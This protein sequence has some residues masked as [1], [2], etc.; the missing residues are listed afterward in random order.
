MYSIKPYL[1][2]L[3]MASLV[4]CS[5]ENSNQQLSTSKPSLSVSQKSVQSG[6]SV[7]FTINNVVPNTISHWAVSAASGYTIDSV[8][9]Y[10]N[11]KITFTQPGNYT[12]T[13]EMKTNDCNPYFIAN[14]WLDSCYRTATS[15]GVVSSTVEVK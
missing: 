12:V 4:S 8:Y 6:Q 1:C 9:S 14:N 5:R 7:N 10:A 11:T 2:L 3:L 13:A 15:K